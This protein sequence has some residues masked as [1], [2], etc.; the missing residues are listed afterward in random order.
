M[1]VTLIAGL[2]LALVAAAPAGAAPANDDVDDAV[3]LGAL[4]ARVSGATDDATTERDEPAS[5]CGRTSGSVWYRLRADRRGPIAVTLEAEGTLQA[6]VGVFRRTRTSFQPVACRRTNANGRLL[7]AFYGRRDREY[8]VLVGTERGSEPGGFRLEVSRP[9]PRSIPPGRA[10][11]GFADATVHPLLDADDAWS[12]DF[13]R[14][15]SYRINLLPSRDCIS[16]YL[17]PPR[18]YRFTEDEVPL[19]ELDCGG[20]TLFTPGPDGGGRYSLL[21]VSASGKRV[22]QRYRLV[23]AP[24]EADDVAPGV[25]LGFAA[26]REDRLSGRGIDLLDLYRFRAGLTSELD[27]RLRMSPKARFTVS[28]VRPTGEPVA[29]E[30]RVRPGRVVL[31]HRLDPGH[32]Y[33][34]VRSIERS[35][36]PYSLSLRVRGITATD[37]LVGGQRFLQVAPGQTQ[38]LAATVSSAGIGGR[39]RFQFDRRDPLYGWQFAETL[40]V[41]V[42]PSGLATVGWIPSGFGH[43]R[44]RARFLG[45]DTAASSESSY[46]RI[47]VAE[48]LGDVA[49]GG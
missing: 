28:V 38:V 22:M 36:G 10:F 15:R 18:T 39:V 23:V 20:Y 13:E 12:L 25:D 34:A 47:F 27:L 16:G 42:G 26:D 14:G 31:R 45:T 46:T 33:L 44:V 32:Y 29:V 40:V 4:P 3:R 49:G 5:G 2:L 17:Y 24:A 21:V 6:V 7:V 1:R 11:D 41:P 30:P 48:P 35:G 9:E 8:F 43:W 19:A 37:M